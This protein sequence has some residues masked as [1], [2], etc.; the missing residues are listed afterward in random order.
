MSLVNSSPP[1]FIVTSR[2]EMVSAGNVADIPPHFGPASLLINTTLLITT[3]P[4]SALNHT[5]LPLIFFGILDRVSVRVLVRFFVS[6]GVTQHP[7]GSH[8]PSRPLH[9]IFFQNIRFL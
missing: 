4:N 7:K 5:E 2:V 3:P 8:V 9:E 1:D 6:L